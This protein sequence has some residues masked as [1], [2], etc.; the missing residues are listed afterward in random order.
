LS[1]AFESPTYQ[2]ERKDASRNHERQQAD[3]YPLTAGGHGLPQER[4]IDMSL[5]H[6][7]VER[8]KALGRIP[9][10]FLRWHPD[11]V[12]VAGLGAVPMHIR[13]VK[14]MTDFAAALV[15]GLIVLPLMPLI[16]LAIKLDSA[17]PVLYSQDRLGQHGKLFRIYKFRSMRT[18]AEAAGAQFATK[19]DTRV[20]RVGRFMR[21]TRIDELPQL[22]DVLR[23]DMSIVGPRPERPEHIARIEQEIPEFSLRLAVKPGLTGWAQTKYQYAATVDELRQKLEYDLYYI[24]FISLRMELMI[25]LRTIKVVLGSKGH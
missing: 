5:E 13:A 22:W 20:T 24:R 16:V 9:L 19:N 10:L 17:G 11:I 7:A 25:L 12:K 3:L 2:E 21:K 14:R 1:S 6:A 8:C 4:L 23:G 15:L 18:D